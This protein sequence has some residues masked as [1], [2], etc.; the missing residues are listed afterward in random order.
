MLKSDPAEKA[1]FVLSHKSK[2]LIKPAVSAAQQNKIVMGKT[3]SSGE[4]ISKYPAISTMI[5]YLKTVSGAVMT[6][7]KGIIAP[8]LMTSDKALNTVRIIRKPAWTLRFLFK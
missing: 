6:A 4:I 7:M 1:N 3:K 2:P 5:S 8:R